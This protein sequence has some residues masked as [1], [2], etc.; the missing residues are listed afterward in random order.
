MDSK[1][2]VIKDQWIRAALIVAT[3]TIL[4][5]YSTL[6]A[7]HLFSW[8]NGSIFFLTISLPFNCFLTILPHLFSESSFSSEWRSLYY[9]RKSIKKMIACGYGAFLLG[10]FFFLINL[11]YIA[12][13]VFGITCYCTWRV[14]FNAGLETNKE[15]TNRKKRDAD[16]KDSQSG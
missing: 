6:E 12:A 16:S 11:S 1:S 4:N 14:Q 15:Y 8:V 7:P 3:T 13:V 10:F 2:E 9:G 5:T